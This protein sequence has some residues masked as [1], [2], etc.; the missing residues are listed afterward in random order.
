[1][2][3]RDFMTTDLISCHPDDT[4]DMAAHKMLDHNISV[5]PIIND[6]NEICGIFT[7]SDFVGKIVEIPHALADVTKL[8]GERFYF[9][10]VDEIYKKAKTK[11]ISEVMSHNPVTIDVNSTLNDLIHLMVT[12]G[13]KRIPVLDGI[14]VVGLI[15]RKDLVKA[16]I[17]I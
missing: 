16:F 12:K 17:K 13:Y 14:K 1:M 6:N 3:T 11:K 4:V 10:D 8:L 7:E 5:I 15:T 9:R 2:Q